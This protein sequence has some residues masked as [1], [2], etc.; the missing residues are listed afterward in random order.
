MNFYNPPDVNNYWSCRVDANPFEYIAQIIK[1]LDLNQNQLVSNPGNA[2][3][4]FASDAG[5]NKNFGRPGACDGPNAI[6]NSLGG[7]PY[8]G[9]YLL[10]DAGNIEHFDEKD[11]ENAQLELAKAVFKLLDNQ[12]LPIILGGGHE[13]AFGHYQGLFNFYQKDIAI[14][15]FDAHFDLRATSN[16]SHPSTSGT[17]FRQI[18]Q[19]LEK[20]QKSFDYCCIGI[21]PHANTK[22]LFDY[23]QKHQ[24]QYLLAQDIHQNPNNF[25]CILKVIKQHELIY[26][27]VCLDVFAAHFAPGV[28]APQVLGINPS[29]VLKA[30][31]LL[32]QSGKVIALDIVELNPKYDIDKHTAKLASHLLVNFLEF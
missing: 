14:V 15:N 4:G 16:I 19:F 17:P 2:I 8:H 22:A 28:S 13:T 3:L 30:L 1:P 27:S 9:K 31:Q 25:D 32:K 10:Y 26:V 23:A 11:L 18:K 24:V 5:V 29:Y 6:R 21:Q 7:I 20:Y 12:Q